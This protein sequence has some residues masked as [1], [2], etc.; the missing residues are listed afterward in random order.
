MLQ[1]QKIS[2]DG[3]MAISFFFATL[4]KKHASL[5]MPNLRKSRLASD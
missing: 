4:V 5:I 2:T 3:S 1:R